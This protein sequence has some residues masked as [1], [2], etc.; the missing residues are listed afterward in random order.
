[1]HRS[2]KKKKKILAPA[3]RLGINANRSFSVDGVPRTRV[4]K[5]VDAIVFARCRYLTRN[6]FRS[7]ENAQL[8]AGRNQPFAGIIFENEYSPRQVAVN[9]V[10]SASAKIITT[11]EIDAKTLSR[12]DLFFY[13]RAT[14]AFLRRRFSITAPCAPASSFFSSSTDARIS[15]I[16]YYLLFG[17]A[18]LLI[19]IIT[20]YRYYYLL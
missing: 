11:T 13:L 20:Y 17:T 3:Y 7:A 16:V 14:C 1:M 6:Y 19:I 2:Q 18:V 12:T 10:R 9:R 5:S 8:S 15:I 4:N